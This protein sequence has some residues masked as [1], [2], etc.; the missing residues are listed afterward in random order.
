M[1]RPRKSISTSRRMKCPVRIYKNKKTKK[2]GLVDKKNII[3]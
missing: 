2:W 3:I 1:I